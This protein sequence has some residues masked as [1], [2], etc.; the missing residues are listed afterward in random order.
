MVHAILTS[1]MLYLPSGAHATALSGPPQSL[2][3]SAVAFSYTLD[4]E[5]LLV[6]TF[7]LL[8]RLAYVALEGNMKSFSF[9]GDTDTLESHSSFQNGLTP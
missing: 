3:S 6:G 2:V 1:R 4:V 5:K 8:E 7:P 9:R